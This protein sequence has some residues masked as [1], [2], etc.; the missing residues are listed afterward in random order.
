MTDPVPSS[1]GAQGDR[2]EPSR[3]GRRIV[4]ALLALLLLAL[5]VVTCSLRRGG[6]GPG[7]D[8][9]A[10]L[11]PDSATMRPGTRLDG[12]S[13]AGA[14]GDSLAD[15]AHLADSATSGRGGDTLARRIVRRTGPRG[16]AP[17]GDHAEALDTAAKSSRTASSDTLPP[18]VFLD[19]APGVH[20]AP[21][22][23]AII[24]PEPGGVPLCGPDPDHLAVCRDL[25]RVR[26]RADFWISAED[27]AGNRVRPFRVKY[28]VDP[29][30]SRCGTRRIQLPRESG[31]VCV[32]AWEYPNDPSQPVRTSV[33]WETADALCARQGKRLCAADELAEACRG[34]EGWKYPYGNDYRVGW[35]Q[36]DDA[37]LARGVERP[38]CRSWWGGYQ[39]VGNAWEWTSTRNGSTYLVSGGT[40]TGGPDIACGRTSRSFY[41]QNRY[42][43]V[44][45]R[46]CQGP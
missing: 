21:V 38:A 30:A 40:W 25:R 17:R 23:V 43:A 12:D 11:V 35:C 26:D 31:D 6:S 20:A 33:N 5:L 8:R 32:D 29:D 18:V 37:A 45:F 4:A 42:E 16:L 3:R 13:A 2:R 9:G 14:G 15:R 34:P 39:L 46:C 22:D 19:P 28:V 1:S 27:S 24:V 44:G 41:A 7:G 10:A 36:V